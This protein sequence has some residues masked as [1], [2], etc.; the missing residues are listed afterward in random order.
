MKEAAF[1]MTDRAIKIDKRLPNF[2]GGRR[3]LLNPPPEQTFQSCSHG[4]NPK[5]ADK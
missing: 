2:F 3:G 5:I 4:A 1:A